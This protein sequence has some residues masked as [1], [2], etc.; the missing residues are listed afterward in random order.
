M[1]TLPSAGGVVIVKTGAPPSMS[2][3]V[4]WPLTVTSSEVETAGAVAVG[5]SFTA[6]TASV[7]VWG[8]ASVSCPPFAV[9][10][11]SMTRNVRLAILAPLTFAGGVQVRF[12]RFAAAITWL[13]VTTT[14]DSRS[15]PDA[16][17]VRIVTSR[18]AWAGLSFVSLKPK[19]A[20][21]KV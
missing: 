10:P 9:P 19:S 3:T 11:S 21:A 18:S 16:G 4:I 20:T 15:V 12:T 17:N 8:V 14:P 5:A 6:V 13:A 1:A 2:V 7:I